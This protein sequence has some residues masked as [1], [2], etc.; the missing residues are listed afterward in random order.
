MF[1]LTTATRS[2]TRCNLPVP[3]RRYTMRVDAVV[4]MAEYSSVSD[5]VNLPEEPE[6]RRC[7]EALAVH[8]C[9]EYGIELSAA[10]IAMSRQSQAAM[11]A[12]RVPAARF[13]PAPRM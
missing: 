4:A 2:V 1:C 9:A 6:K 3:F 5:T 8:F 11:R 7:V 10:L 13:D 12:C